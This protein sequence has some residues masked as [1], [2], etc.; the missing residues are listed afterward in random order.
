M[1]KT[2]LLYLSA[3]LLTT[4][5]GCNN[6]QLDLNDPSVTENL[7]TSIDPST[8]MWYDKPAGKWEEA[9][10]V[11][12]GRL[13]AMVF[14]KYG[15]EQIQLNEETY[16]SG[17]PYSTVV[18]GG[19]KALPQIQK[20][21]F[22]GE[23]LKA[24]KLF[25]RHLM[26]YPVEQQKYQALANL[27]LFFQEQDTVINYQRSLDLTTGIATVKYSKDGVNYKREV[28]AS[29]PDQTIVVRLTADK[30]GSISFD[31]ELRGVRN[32][33]HSNTSP[34]IEDGT[35]PQMKAIR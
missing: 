5:I 34:I 1:K 35:S 20:Y 31:A 9:L 18:A 33:A 24:H 28:V 4:F 11:G 13:G 26:G 3:C 14:G 17:G 10:P 30:P 8:F 7:D 21:I 27:H 22:E 15:E 32:S 16:W 29:H 6:S 25:G 2:G 12:N 23:P 19:H